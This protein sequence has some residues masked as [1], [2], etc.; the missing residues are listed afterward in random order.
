MK[1]L[2]E[3]VRKGE[4]ESSA[5]MEKVCLLNNIITYT[6]FTHLY[7]ILPYLFEGG[8]NLRGDIYFSTRRLCVN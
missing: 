6:V 8:I 7:T 4:K 2:E 5:K 3:G 1:Q